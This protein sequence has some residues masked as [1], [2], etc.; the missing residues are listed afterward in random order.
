[1]PLSKSVRRKL[2]HTRV[3]TCH[4]YQRDDGLWDIEGHMVDTKPYAFNSIEREGGFI[5]ANEALH[6][7]WVRLT[8]DGD[9][10]IHAIEAVTDWAPFTGCP[11]ASA[12]FQGLVGVTIGNGWMRLIKELMGGVRGC[13]HL[14]E[15][16]GPV[17]T[18]AFQTIMS[19]NPGFYGDAAG[20]LTEPPPYINSC[21]ELHESGVIVKT[22][23]P[24]FY[25]PV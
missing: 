25:R 18:T 8:L 7:M 23:W 17:A 21:H 5:D 19:S 2:M 10:K 20:V 14:T 1:M 3:V 24:Q 13:T 16:L 15:L 22:L 11:R 6:D 9:Y 12:V 4:G